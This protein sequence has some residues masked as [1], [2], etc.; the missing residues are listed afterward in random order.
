M[1]N[2]SALFLEGHLLMYTFF[3]QIISGAKARNLD[4]RRKPRY[5]GYANSNK[6]EVCPNGHCNYNFCSHK[7]HPCLTTLHFFKIRP[8][9]SAK[10]WFALAVNIFFLN[11]LTGYFVN[12]VSPGSSFAISTSIRPSILSVGH[13]SSRASSTPTLMLYS[14]DSVTKSQSN[15]RTF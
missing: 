3:Q 2:S 4:Q 6:E 7:T 5:W 12:I 10:K 15:Q 11:N 9:F 14:E 8:K 13:V 1:Q